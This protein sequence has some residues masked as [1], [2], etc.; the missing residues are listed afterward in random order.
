MILAK[1]DSIHKKHQEHYSYDTSKRVLKSNIM[2]YRKYNNGDVFIKN[3]STGQKGLIKEGQ[4]LVE[5][6]N[7]FF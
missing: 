2:Y 7:L 1:L 3:K 4:N 5:A 6:I